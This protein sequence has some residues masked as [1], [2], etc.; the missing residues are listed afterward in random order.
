MAL[1]AVLF[2][3][4]FAYLVLLTLLRLSHKRAVAEAT[5]FDF[6]LTLILGDMVDD[7]LGAKVGL[8]TFTVAVA[9]LALCHLLVSLVTYR[10]AGAHDLVDGRPTVLLS[11]RVPD[12]AGLRAEL[13]SDA[14]LDGLLR[15]EGVGRESWHTLETVRL[16]T[17]GEISVAREESAGP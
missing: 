6:V 12:P 3:A 17:S 1:D 7:V 15:L 5:P 13:V 4:A 10:S 11:Q 14:E 2:R 9:T 16:E 8:A